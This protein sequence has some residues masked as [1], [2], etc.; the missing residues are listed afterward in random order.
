MRD[1]LTI[2]SIQKQL[3]TEIETLL[4]LQAGSVTPDTD[5]PA[6]GISSL[7]F[8]SLV[9]NIEQ[10]FSVN[11]MEIGLKIDDT[12]SPRN[13]AAVIRAGLAA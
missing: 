3:C 1:A 9:L 2:E 11:L 12:K 5:L 10:R 13:L 6:L 7:D 8:V 4:S